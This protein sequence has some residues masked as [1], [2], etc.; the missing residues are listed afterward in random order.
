[1]LSILKVKCTVNKCRPKKWI[2]HKVILDVNC[3]AGVFAESVLYSHHCLILFRQFW[4]EDFNVVWEHR[5]S[6]VDDFLINLCTFMK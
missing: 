5:N 4:D 2:F 3:S 1:M 6:C